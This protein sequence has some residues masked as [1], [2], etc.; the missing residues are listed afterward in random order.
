[1]SD[2]ERR[3][4]HT[5]QEDY[6]L[7]VDLDEINRLNAQHKAVTL[8]FDGLLPP[9]ALA[10]FELN[11]GIGKVLD[12]GCGTGQWLIDLTN[13]FPNIQATGVDL[14]PIYPSVYPSQITFIIRSILQPFPND[15]MGTFDLVHARFLITGIRDFCSLLTRLG[16]LLRP[17]GVLVIVEPEM[18]SRCLDGKIEDK[19]PSMARFGDI[20]REAMEKFGIDMEAA[21]QIPIYL[22]Q[23]GQFE[24]V[25]KEMRELPMSDWPEDARLNQIGK[26]QLPNALA[27]P[28]TIRKLVIAS[29][30]IS[31]ADFEELKRGYQGELRLGIGKLVL[32]IWSIWA[33]KV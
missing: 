33:T 15:W 12:I 3:K 32:P 31:E 17:G 10:K 11:G 24:K 19:C 27:M 6:P 23:D 29:G 26:A 14:S 9:A 20:S 22:S 8:L 7:P 18:E 1:M 5:I 21:V 4:S 16:S 13:Q 2:I 25:N 28:D 30:I